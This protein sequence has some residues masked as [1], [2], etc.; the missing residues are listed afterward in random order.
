MKLS[1]ALLHLSE[2]REINYT[3]KED[4][5]VFWI[6]KNGK[7]I[8]SRMKDVIPDSGSRKLFMDVLSQ[9]KESKDI[10]DGLVELVKSGKLKMD[11]DTS[12]KSP[13]SGGGKF[14]WWKMAG[15]S[16]SAIFYRN[17]KG[18]EIQI[19]VPAT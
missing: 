17:K 13:F 6:P 19:F 4:D 8:R 9:S 5:V 3:K 7:R 10:A 18:E 16:S 11:I 1:E 2:A 14:I 15:M 12:V